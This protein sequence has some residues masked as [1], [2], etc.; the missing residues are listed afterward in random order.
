MKKNTLTIARRATAAAVIALLCHIPAAQAQKALHDPKNRAENNPQDICH[1]IVRKQPRLRG[2]ARLDPL[3]DNT[4]PAFQQAISSPV[5]NTCLIRI[6]S[7]TANNGIIRRNDYS[8]R[9]AF[10]ADNTRLILSATSGGNWYLHDARSGQS[11]KTLPYLAGDAEPHWHPTQPEIL[12]YLNTNGIGMTVNELNVES[13]A[14][15]IVG[16]LGARLRERWPD[17]TSA[18]TRAEGSPSADGRY[19]CF[20]AE[21]ANWQTRGIFIWDMQQDRILGSMNVNARPDHVSMS[22]SGKYCVISGD[23]ASGTRAWNHDFSR[24]TQLHHKSEHSDLA[25]NS[26]GEDIYVSVDYQ[27]NRGDIYM[28]HLDSGRRTPLIQLYDNGSS[29]AVHFSGKSYDKP[30]WIL[31]STYGE[32]PDRRGNRKWMQRKIFA[33]G[34]EASPRI[35]NISYAHSDSIDYWAEPQATASRDFTRI[36]FNSTWGTRDLNQLSTYM[37][38]IHGNALR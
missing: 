31:V 21:T 36:L 18:W 9:Q 28:T 24:H 12:Y 27:S 26:R 13:G 6:T 5:Y 17:V 32:S 34:L 10:N 11:L 4:P 38:V 29:S 20:M 25:L 8:R 33:L 37:S 1:D 22:P 30:G 15:R 23:D 7:K 16:D 2:G 14:T 35:R 3:P 19:W